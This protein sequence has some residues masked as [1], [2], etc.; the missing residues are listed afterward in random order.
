[1]D[2][3]ACVGTTMSGSPTEVVISLCPAGPGTLETADRSA[4][5]V[6]SGDDDLA[7]LNWEPGVRPMATIRLPEGN[8][9]LRATWFGTRAAAA[10]RDSDVG[11]EQRSPEHIVVDFWPVP[12]LPIC[13]T[14]QR[15]YGRVADA[16]T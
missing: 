14:G 2:G 15:P 8:I 6:L 3:F 7:I 10:H 1:M 16:I 4:E 9:Q 13:V 5:P 12:E 11:G